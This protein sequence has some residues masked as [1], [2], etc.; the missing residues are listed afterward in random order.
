MADIVARRSRCVRS[1]VGC[2]IVTPDNR[3]AAASYNGPPAAMKVRGMCDHWCPR[4]RSGDAPASDYDNC[5]SS[6]AEMNAIARADR[7]AYLGGVMYTTRVPC[8]DCAKVIANSGV[9]RVV[10]RI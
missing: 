5:V 8:W 9:H 2:I 4:G 1:Q 7:S 10:C 3:V 6:H